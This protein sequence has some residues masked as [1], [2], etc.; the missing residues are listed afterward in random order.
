LQGIISLLRL[1][2]LRLG[3]RRA[4]IYAP[5]RLVGTD[6]DIVLLSA[7]QAF[8]LFGYFFVAFYLY[9]LLVLGELTVGGQLN[10]VSGNAGRGHLCG[11]FLPLDCDGL[12]RP[13]QLGQAGFLRIDP[14]ADNFG[15][16]VFIFPSA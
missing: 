14:K 4:V 3:P 11:L 15:A 5:D 8:Y 2:V 16:G 6:A 12:L 7:F 1:H 9:Q 13:G 10:L